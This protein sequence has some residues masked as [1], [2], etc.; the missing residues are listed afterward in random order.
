MATPAVNRLGMAG[1]VQSPARNIHLVNALIADVAVAGIP[2]PVPAEL[3]VLV[4]GPLRGRPEEQ[5]PIDT[6]RHGGVPPVAHRAAAVLA[7]GL[8]PIKVFDGFLPLPLPGSPP[9]C[10]AS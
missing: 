2:H 10:P 5:G 8:F 1:L 7:E 9:L 3:A 6:R 4:V